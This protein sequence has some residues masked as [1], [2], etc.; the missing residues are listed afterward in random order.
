MPPEANADWQAEMLPVAVVTA[1]SRFR[2]F[3]RGYWMTKTVSAW[4]RRRIRASLVATRQ[5]LPTTGRASLKAGRTVAAGK[6]ASANRCG[7]F[8]PIATEAEAC[9]LTNMQ[10][11]TE[12]D[13][14]P[15]TLNAWTAQRQ[16]AEETTELHACLLAG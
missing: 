5:S 1:S 7:S 11:L 8:D 3:H 9:R 13:Q 6:L 12:R 16:A 2:F 14:R 10:P 15:K 4:C